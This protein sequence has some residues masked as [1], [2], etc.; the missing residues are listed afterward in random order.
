MRIIHN[1]TLSANHLLL[2]KMPWA[3]IPS[4]AKGQQLALLP[5]F[6]LAYMTF[7]SDSGQLQV[8]CRGLPRDNTAPHGSGAC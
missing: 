1:T 8:S 7:V 6:R 2:V 3:G 4:F 5:D